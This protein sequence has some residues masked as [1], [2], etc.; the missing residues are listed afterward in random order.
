MNMKTPEL[1]VWFV[2]FVAIINQTRPK[3]K[4][5]HSEI[6]P[7]MICLYLSLCLV[8]V[9]SWMWPK[10]LD[11]LHIICMQCIHMYL[12]HSVRSQHRPFF[13]CTAP[14]K[15]CVRT[16]QTV[17][18]DILFLCTER[19]STERGEKKGGSSRAREWIDR[20][21]DGSGQIVAGRDVIKPSKR[22]LRLTN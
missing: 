15:L 16:Q 5:C 9:T 8:I 13:T 10:H 4:H 7:L 18:V 1:I 3:R 6:A 12:I 21:W 11:M 14:N 2:D 17:P 19:A 22:V 20:W